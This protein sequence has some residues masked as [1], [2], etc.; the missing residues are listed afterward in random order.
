MN[1]LT[2]TLPNSLGTVI[3]TSSALEAI[4]SYKQDKSFKKEAGG[5]LFAQ[6]EG[7]C[8]RIV[9]A[10]PPKKKDLRSRFGFRPHRPTEKLEIHKKY[11]DAG[12]HF[13]G[14]WHTHPQ[15]V[16]IPSGTDIESVCKMMNDSKHD[17]PGLL[18]VILGTEDL[19]NGLYV[20]FHTGTD[21]HQ[22][23]IEL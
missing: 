15:A 7:A 13:V 11:T 22:L 9:D 20:G 10:T 23:Q 18:L 16:P 17:L 2:Y 14:D 8:I 4:S 1:E 5:Q 6:F 21:L 12:L 3:F 19:P